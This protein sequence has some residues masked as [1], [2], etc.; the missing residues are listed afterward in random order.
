MVSLLGP[1]P[2]AFLNRSERS[3][4][5]WDDQGMTLVPWTFSKENNQMQSTAMSRIASSECPFTNQATGNWKGTVPV[6]DQSFEVRERRLN[7]ED[8]ALFLRLMRTILRWMPEDRPSAEELAYDDF[9][10]Q[11]HHQLAFQK[12]EP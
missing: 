1:P 10:M 9:L 11:P 3:R 5:Y 8:K 2:V 6:P 4:L 12:A 7:D